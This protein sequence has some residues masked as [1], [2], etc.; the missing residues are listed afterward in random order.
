MDAVVISHLSKYKSL[1]NFLRVTSLDSL[2]FTLST[3]Q[4][5]TWKRE[6]LNL[7]EPVYCQTFHYGMRE[8]Q[9]VTC[10][11]E[12][13]RGMRVNTNSSLRRVRFDDPFF[14]K[15]YDQNG[16]IVSETI[17]TQTNY[18][19]GSFQQVGTITKYDRDGRV[20]RQRRERIRTRN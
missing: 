8:Q 10:L 16:R 9:L 14:D 13:F 18:N 5:V 1:E 4:K 15:T 12:K 17:R 3:S 20:I 2:P 6:C 11:A 19:D 7:A